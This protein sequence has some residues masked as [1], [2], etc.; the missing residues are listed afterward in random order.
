[1]SNARKFRGSF[2]N[3][4]EFW[5]QQVTIDHVQVNEN[6]YGLTI[7]DLWS[8][9]TQFSPTDDKRASTTSMA[10]RK[11][12]GNRR[13]Q[14]IYS[15]NAPEFGVAARDIGAL[16]DTST[17]GVHENN[18]IVERLNQEIIRGTRTVLVQA[19]LPQSFW[20]HASEHFTLMRNVIARRDNSAWYNTHGSSF[21]GK[22]IP[23]G[24]KVIFRPSPIRLDGPPKMSPQTAVGI[25]AGY[26]IQSGYTWHGEYKVWQLEDFATACMSTDARHTA[27]AFKQPQRVKAIELPI[28]GISFPLKQNYDVLNNTLSGLLSQTHIL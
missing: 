13:I 16:H 17:P 14:R 4:A 20:R 19:G 11:F 9:L 23:F 21:H 8:G 7:Y 15:D 27:K 2:T 24:A 18:C 3:T 5:G 25:F 10:L 26:T 6:E 12:A 1:M 22:L 28:E